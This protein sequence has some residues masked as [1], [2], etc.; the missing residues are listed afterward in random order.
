MVTD[1][2]ELIGSGKTN[3]PVEFFATFYV[4]GWDGGETCQYNEPRPIPPSK[5]GNDLASIWGHFIAYV[6][7]GGGGG[8]EDCEPGGINPCT[9]VLTE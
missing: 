8:Q 3:V 4:T 1:F 2:S 6:N 5:K 9:P 7:P